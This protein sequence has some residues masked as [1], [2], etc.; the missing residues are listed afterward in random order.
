[1]N[2]K[3]M[4]TETAWNLLAKGTSEKDLVGFCQRG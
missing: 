3:M 1:L 2:V 4:Q